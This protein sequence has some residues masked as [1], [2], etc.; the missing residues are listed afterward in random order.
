MASLLKSHQH[1]EQY[2]EG[3]A[4]AQASLE[5]TDTNPPAG[6]RAGPPSHLQQ[7]CGGVVG[8]TSP[9]A[10]THRMD[11]Q[12][13]VKP[14]TQEERQPAHV[15]LGEDPSL[16]IQG[17]LGPAKTGDPSGSGREGKNLLLPGKERNG[18]EAEDNGPKTSAVWKVH[19][20]L[21]M[22][23]QSWDAVVPDAF[24]SAMQC[25]FLPQRSDF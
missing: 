19:P 11:S 9:S 2:E 23:I 8:P 16:G 1:K 13:R 20:P 15:P 18:R 3:P 24:I 25:S 22:F 14:P 4:P 6:E 7:G 21:S 12:A 10:P 5:L 17:S